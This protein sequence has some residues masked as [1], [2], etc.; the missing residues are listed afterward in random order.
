MLHPIR[1]AVVDDH[2]LVRE[3]IIHAIGASAEDITVVGEGATA[4][5]A[6]E[7]V[8]TLAPD[9]LLLD[10]SIPGL[11]LVA[12][13]EMARMQFQTRVIVLTASE[14]SGDVMEAL[15]HGVSG[16][17]LKGIRGSDLKDIIRRVH[18]SER[19]VSPEL[20]ARMLSDLSRPSVR[21]DDCLSRREAEIVR[22][23]RQGCCNKDIAKHL[24]I[25][26]KT[27]KHYMTTIFRK[28]EVRNRTELAVLNPASRPAPAQAAGPVI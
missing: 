18:R 8:R 13:E 17:I 1:V 15:R 23:V 4:A 16:Y 26:E 14:D 10:L 2:P 22:L 9:I 27:V 7:L 3:G 21:A 5:E 20:A 28:L 12:L 19:Y 24:D 25:S 6:V 11:G